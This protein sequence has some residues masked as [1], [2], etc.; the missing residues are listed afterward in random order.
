MG[1]GIR[2][3]APGQDFFDQ[4]KGGDHFAEMK[5][6]GFGDSIAGYEK[7]QAAVPFAEDAPTEG[8]G[9]EEKYANGGGVHPHGNHVV[10][11]KHH[12]NGMVVH[13]H[14]HGGYSIHHPDGHVTHHAA[15]GEVCHAMGGEI[16]MGH[17]HGHHVTHKT[18]LP[19]GME[20]EHHAHG[21]Q[22]VHHPDGHVSHH[23]ASGD[24][25]M[26]G[27]A[28]RF[29]DGGDVAQDK[30]MVTK[31]VH[32]HE[33]H[34]HHGEHTEMHLARGGMPRF[35]HGSMKRKGH[36]IPALNEGSAL[37]RPPHNPNTTRTPRNVMPGGQMGY[38]VQPSD[39]SGAMEPGDEGMDGGMGNSGVTPM[40]T[41]GKVRRRCRE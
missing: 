36:G 3:M 13:H 39:E 16:G 1:K 21:G 18:N 5:D 31:G 17:P 22:T 20:I 14:A 33:D 25:L 6:F 9:M 2:H 30:A 12:K 29:G 38:G 7:H 8:S 11:V 19:G 41:G 34:L 10:D 40:R 23:S 15:G 27:G 4:S 26:D 24:V 35:Q 32:E 37:N 28:S